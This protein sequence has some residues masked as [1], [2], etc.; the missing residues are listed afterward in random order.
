MACLLDVK[1]QARPLEAVRRIHIS[2]YKFWT[3]GSKK[4]RGTVFPGIEILI[5]GSHEQPTVNVTMVS[6][7]SRS[8]YSFGVCTTANFS[9]S[10]ILVKSFFSSV[11]LKIQGFLLEQEVS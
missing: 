9:S 11:V 1:T 8:V 4:S 7:D 10:G 3:N 6:A 5:L 2:E